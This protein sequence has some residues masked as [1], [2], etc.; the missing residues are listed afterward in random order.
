MA[1]KSIV[2]AHPPRRAAL[3]PL[4]WAALG[5]V[6]LI[7]GSTYLA[8]RV[9]I[10]T[11][12]P[13]LM[14]SAR[15][16]VAGTVLYAISIRRGDREGDRPGPAQWR[17]ATTVGAAL[18]VG[19]N[20]GVVWAEQRVPSSIVA[21]LVSAMPLWMAAIGFV[22]FRERLRWPA[23]LGLAL[24]FA[25]VGLLVRPSGGGRVD[26]L[27][28]GVVLLAAL[29][30]AAGSLHSRRAP[31]PS[32]PLV[33]TS[34]E[35]LCGGALLAVAG[36]VSGEPGRL[37]AVSAESALALGYL[38]AF[39]SLVAFSAYVW[40]LT[41][42]PISI[43][44]TYAYVNPVVAVVL[45]W[46]MLGERVTSGMLLAGAVI[47]LAVALIVRTRPTPAPRAGAPPP[48]EVG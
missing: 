43:V 28:A 30:W 4:V 27:G 17:A 9:A 37:R 23:V 21:L 41:A 8:I 14:A 44:S 7:W 19:G 35:M 16:L 36:I 3:P 15:F 29:S 1:E 46:A 2:A 18:L 22:A 20:G 47:V 5:S 45:G 10:R 6:Y 42:A 11:I 39:G 12:P 26:P 24:G 48:E 32:R 38:I 13:F 34:M 31:L 33:A 25:G 40:L